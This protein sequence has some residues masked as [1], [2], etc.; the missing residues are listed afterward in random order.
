MHTMDMDTLMEVINM[1]ITT[2]IIHMDIINTST[3]TIITIHMSTPRS[4]I[5]LGPTNIIVSITTTT[6]VIVMVMVME[7]KT[8]EESF[9]T[10]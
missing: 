7:M 6:M 10:S 2:M 1:I 3:V 4:H 8:C 9:Y 5:Q